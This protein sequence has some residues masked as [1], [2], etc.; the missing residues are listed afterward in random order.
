MTDIQYNASLT[1]AR[2]MKNE[3]FGRVIAGPVGSGKTVSCIFELLR[4]ACEQ[5]PGDD[6]LRYTRFAIVR[7]TLKQLKDTVLKDIVEWLEGVAQYKVSDSTIYIEIGDVRSEWILIPLDNPEDQRRLL[8]MQLTG[9]WMSEAIEMDINLVAPL[10]GRIGR[11]PSGRSGAANW[12]G[13]IADTNMPAEGSD[14][15]KFMTEGLPANWSAFFQPSGLSEDA[16]N[17]N[18]LNQT[19]DTKALP[20]NHPDRI[21]RGKLYYK[22][23]VDMYGEESDWVKRYVKAEFGDDPSGTAVFRTSFRQSFHVVEGLEPI[24]GHPLLIGQDFGR[25]PCSVIC[26]VDHRGRLLVLEEV[27][28][29]D[30]GLE[31]HIEQKLKPVLNQERYLGRPLAMIGDPSGVSKSSIYE[32]TTFDVLK[33]MGF[34]AYPAPTNDIDPRIRAVEAW[35]MKQSDGG[36]AILFDKLRCPT[37]IRAM[38]GGYRYAKTKSGQRKPLPDKNEYSHI[39]DALQYACLA[40]HGRMTE[41]MARRLTRRVA[42]DNGVRAS[43]AG[44]T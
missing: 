20:L 37:L 32:E 43:A 41:M 17:L 44:W 39:A 30:I 22:R 33:R 42:N 10:S 9:A 7:Q 35:L 3:S 31:Q 13:I 2:F 36:G 25:D 14:W 1:C 12:S 5:T 15:H 27:A 34:A 38:G 6:G 4:R 40:A 11:Y 16:E 28:A 24:F 26:Q 23:F 21:A 19:P 8:S 18:Y 29:E